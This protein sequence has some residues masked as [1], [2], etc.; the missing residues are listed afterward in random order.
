[1]EVFR[2]VKWWWKL[3]TE[4]E[5]FMFCAILA[6]LFVF[7]GMAIFGLKFLSIILLGSILALFVFLMYKL[8]SGIRNQWKKY[9]QD[10]DEEAQAI[11]HV[12]SGTEPAIDPRL[13]GIARHWAKRR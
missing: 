5:K 12:L 1:M 10:R 8:F 13:A 3:R 9:K 11:V 6:M 7:I 2:F 4:N